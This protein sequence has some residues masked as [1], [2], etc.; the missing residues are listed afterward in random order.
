[1]SDVLVLDLDGTVADA[2]HREHYADEDDYD[3]FFD[4]DLVYQDEPIAK[5]QKSLP[6]IL[7]KF[8]RLVFLTGRPSRLKNVTQEWL[9]E[10]FNLD[11]GDYKLYMREN[12]DVR[13]SKIVKKELIEEFLSPDD[14]A[15]FIDDETE[16]LSMMGTFGIALGVP[17]AW[18]VLIEEEFEE[19]EE[20][21]YG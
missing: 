16:N 1:M 14:E 3:S 2:Q 9:S 4:P 20:Q 13:P 17:E 15:V 12:E 18:D 7:P 6:K 19:E 11:T 8:D 21:D 10:H 5:A